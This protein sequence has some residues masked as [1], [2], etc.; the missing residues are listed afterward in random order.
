MQLFTSLTHSHTQGPPYAPR[1]VPAASPPSRAQFCAIVAGE[2]PA[3]RV[4]DDDAAVAFLDVRPLFPGHTLLVPRA[5]VE[6]LADLP[7]DC[8]EP[9]FSRPSAWPGPWRTAWAPPG[10]SWP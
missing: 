4:L 1:V 9:L 7:T 10:R 8:I 3:F 5:H 6:T 2:A